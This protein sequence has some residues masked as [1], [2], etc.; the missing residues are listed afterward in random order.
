MKE[1]GG[2]FELELSRHKEYHPCAIRLNS[3]RN[4]LRYLLKIAQPELLYIPFYICDS[5][6]EAARKE[7]I[8]YTFYH[9]DENFEPLLDERESKANI[10]ILYSNYFGINDQVVRKLST[11]YHNLVVDNA[12]A[13]YSK[14]IEG[15]TTFYS[16]RKFFGIPD[17][18]YLY[19]EKLLNKQL[20]SDLSYERSE[21]LLK[22]WD[23]NAHESY[24]IYKANE[25]EFSK[26]PVKKMSKLTQGIL[27][28]IDYEGAKNI[29][30]R[31]FAYLHNSLSNYNELKISDNNINGPMVYPFLYSKDGLRE[32]LIR[33]KIYV[34][35]YWQEV[36]SRVQEDSLEYKLAKYLIPL[37]IDQ[38]YDRYQ[39]DIIIKAVLSSLKLE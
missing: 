10:F 26:R 22:R 3:G 5:V 20:E 24:S 25:N 2:F 31:N 35:T 30:E 36:K 39:M 32:L 12:Q 34:T 15:I 17:G 21:H 18:S 4:A 16:P 1:I 27:S 14:P 9:L 37:P 8:N 23:V 7:N 38:R 13:F 11:K 19:I 33:N 6:I 29:R 28:S